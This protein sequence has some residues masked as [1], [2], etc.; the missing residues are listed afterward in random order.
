MKPARRHAPALAARHRRLLEHRHGVP[1]V[2]E[3]D[4]GGEPADARPDHDD[5][6]HRRSRAASAG[7]AKAP[8][9]APPAAATTGRRHST[10]F[11]NV[12]PDPRPGVERE[13]AVAVGQRLV[14]AVEQRPDREDA[15]AGHEP[16]EE[17]R[18]RDALV[19]PAAG[20]G[21]VA[22]ARHPRVEE[23]VP[24]GQRARGERDARRAAAARSARP[25]PTTAAPSSP[26]PPRRAAAR[27]R[28]AGRAG[29]STCSARTAAPSPRP[30][31]RPRSRAPPAA[32]TAPRPAARPRASIASA[33]RRR[34]HQP[35]DP[36]RRP[37][38]APRAAAGR[39]RP[40]RRPRARPRSA[41]RRPH[42]NAAIDV[43][44]PGHGLGAASIREP[45]DRRLHAGLGELP[46][47]ADVLVDGRR[48]LP[49]A[50]LARRRRRAPARGA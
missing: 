43:G 29:P 8:I 40:A 23:D 30:R 45:H 15:G 24:G 22:L 4:R 14:V 3:P 13:R 50:R 11:A 2:R 48:A 16:A 35:D 37:D 21:P 12:S 28:P 17:V 32:A 38:Q 7:A 26:T 31:A 42:R 36:A 34:Q 41:A 1:R 33:E 18:G 46:V 10:A 5:A 27:R 6:A 25:R 19:A 20:P 39:R 49:L 9:A 44:E 47:A